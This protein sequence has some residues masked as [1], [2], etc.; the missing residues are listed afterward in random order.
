MSAT[1]TTTGVIAEIREL[2]AGD[3]ATLNAKTAELLLGAI[4]QYRS[5][6]SQVLTFAND[7]RSD[8]ERVAE[9]VAA[10]YRV[11]SSDIESWHGR[12]A[13]SVAERQRAADQIRE[14]CWMLDID[15]DRCDALWTEIEAGR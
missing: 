9:K 12:L 15:G 5:Q 11:Y 10:G 2:A 1:T 14:Y 13:E 8:M 6:T 7:V 3:L 4:R